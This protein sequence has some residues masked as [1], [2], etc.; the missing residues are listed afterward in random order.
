MLVCRLLVAACDGAVKL[1]IS[2]VGLESDFSTTCQDV[3]HNT[4]RITSSALPRPNHRFL[5]AASSAM[6]TRRRLAG[7][8]DF[9]SNGWLSRRSISRADR[10]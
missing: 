9:V 2:R 3:G 4:T 1:L 8:S 6:G 5:V 7:P 10:N